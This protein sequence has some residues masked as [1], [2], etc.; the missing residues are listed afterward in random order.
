[1]SCSAFGAKEHK[2]KRRAAEAADSKTTALKKSKTSATSTAVPEA[3][4]DA[5]W[6]AERHEEREPSH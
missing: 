1:M 3:V 5:F 2:A 6:T 4:A